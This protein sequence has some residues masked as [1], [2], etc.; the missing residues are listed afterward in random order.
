MARR[1]GMTQGHIPAFI[2]KNAAQEDLVQYP[3]KRLEM[4]I[5]VGGT[6]T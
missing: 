2:K 6:F 4:V 3:G 1:L 5:G